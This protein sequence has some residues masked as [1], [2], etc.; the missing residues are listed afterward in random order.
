MSCVD[1]RFGWCWGSW[2]TL[3]AL[4]G[5]I[6]RIAGELGVYPEVLRM[7]VKTAQI[8]GGVVPGTTGADAQ[9]SLIWFS[10]WLVLVESCRCGSGGVEGFELVG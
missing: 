5:P 3:N 6:S 10:G 9:G 4:K 8:G 7:W 2:G 1:V